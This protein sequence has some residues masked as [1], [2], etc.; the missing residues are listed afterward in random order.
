MELWNEGGNI[1]YIGHSPYE[2]NHLNTVFGLIFGSI[3]V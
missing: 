1:R 3:I 2:L